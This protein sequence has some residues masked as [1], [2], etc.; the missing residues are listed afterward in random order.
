MTY[1][2]DVCAVVADAKEDA[3]P[4]RQVGLPFATRPEENARLGISIA[5]A[6]V[7]L[8]ATTNGED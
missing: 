8:T 3:T 7:D 5:T 4:R 2:L 1:G 6:S